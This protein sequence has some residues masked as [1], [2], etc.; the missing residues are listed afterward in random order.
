MLGVLA[1]SGLAVPASSAA[2]GGTDRGAAAAPMIVIMRDQHRAID[3]RAHAAQRRAAVEADTAPLV[4]DAE[5]AGATGV[6]RF[7]VVDGFAATISRA[8]ADRL[9][10]QPG[11]A[12]VVPDSTV[13]VGGLSAADR[14]DIA[15]LG[16]TPSQ[17]SAKGAEPAKDAKAGKPA[18]ASSPAADGTAALPAAPYPVLPGSCP[19]DPSRPQLEPQALQLVRAASQDPTTPQAQSLADGHGVTVGFIADGLNPANPEFVR[20]D[21]TSVFA[22]YQDFTGG[23]PAAKIDGLEAF[24]DASTIAAQGRQTYDISTFVDPANPLP[25][26]CDIVVRGVAPGASLVG[27]QVAGASGVVADSTVLQAIDRAVTVDHVDVLTEALTSNAFPTDGVDPISVADDAAV[28]SGVTV[29]ASAG[30]SGATGTVAAPAVDPAVVSVGSTLT[31]RFQ[32][33][34]GY[35]GARVLATSVADGNPTGFSSGGTTDRAR[36]IDLVAPGSDGWSA[37]D[38]SGKYKGCFAFNGLTPTAIGDFGGTAESSTPVVAGVAA[39]VVQAYER[40]HGGV[41]PSPALVKSIL[42]STAT[43]LGLPADEQGSGQVD[44]YSAVTMASSVRDANGS[45]ASAGPGLER[46]VGAAGDTQLS[47]V[48]AAGAAQSG[49]VTLTNTGTA[50][51]TV[52]A[53]GRTLATTLS[54]QTGSLTVGWN[55]PACPA[56]IEGVSSPAGPVYR[57]YSSTT[58]TVPPGTDFLSGRFAFP[59]GTANGQSIARLALVDPN[60]VY[61]NQSLSQGV[62]DYGRA[63]VRHPAAGT[64]TA[65]FFAVRSPA[66]YHGPVAYEFTSSRYA[67]IGTVTPA[68]A[69]IAPGASATFTVGAPLPAAAGDLSAAVEF[70]ADGAVAQTVPLTLRTLISS[71]SA[72]GTFGGTLTGGNGHPGGVAQT[73]AYYFDVPAGQPNLGVDLALDGTPGHALQVALESPDGQVAAL[74][75]NQVP[76]AGGGTTLTGSLQAYVD[77][78]L[79]GRWT[80]VVEDPNPVV[81]NALS[82]HYSGR[83]RYGLASAAATGLPQ[84]ALP[85]GQPVRATLS[86][87]NTGAAP[88][89]FFADPRLSAP[90]VLTL[91]PAG[92]ATVAFP[93]TTA[94]SLPAYLVPT[95]T[96]ALAVTSTSTIP[97]TLDATAATGSPDLFG[98]AFGTSAAAAALSPDLTAGPWT[99]TP[100]PVGPTTGAVAGTATITATAVAQPLDPAATTSTGDLWAAATDP[101]A[102]A[103]LSP[104]LVAPGQ[105][106]TLTVTFTPTGASGTTVRGTI[107]VDDYSAV[108]GDANELTGI[109]Y[110]Y[111][112]K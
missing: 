13:T 43:D 34:T 93:V 35:G 7:A 17:Q 4:A 27:L 25:A 102:R 36:V 87:T 33:Q 103:A 80:L 50:A 6:K 52:S 32:A 29:V 31:G 106:G 84:G 5:A 41:R 18:K 96:L 39:L 88:A 30:R 109:P 79:A 81:G 11:V 54:D 64:W 44:A 104:V 23:D 91:A 48:G 46:S 71:T 51:R 1:G 57:C 60:G 9:R 47:L 10:A 76:T 75:T 8:E 90:T 12:A 28:A 59:G 20:A 89:Y 56:F 19:A 58:F 53:H 82:Q 61:Q 105:T 77:A 63:D 97:A 42:T 37:C 74:A 83:L 40:A 100:A 72:G 15:A 3:A 110:S 62:S 94:T 65:Y 73:A 68:S 69:T 16:A 38:A 49:T 55:D 99:V 66:A 98:P 95:H 24:G 22:D 70:D 67:P 107:Y 21:G 78:P 101:T 45:P 26:G 111:T 108:L 2:V 85:A 92:S 86:V 112:V 14:S